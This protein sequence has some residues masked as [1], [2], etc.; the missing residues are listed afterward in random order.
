MCIVA[1]VLAGLLV[2]L[3]V[4]VFV[5]DLCLCV[6]FGFVALGFLWLCFVFVWLGLL[7]LF[8][9]T[10][11]THGLWLGREWMLA[12]RREPRDE[13]GAGDR[14]GGTNMRSSTREPTPKWGGGGQIVL[15]PSKLGGLSLVSH[16]EPQK[17]GALKEKMRGS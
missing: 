5:C 9:G 7:C 15:S 16:L 6:C 3:L 1:C 17:R 2:C 13:D 4:C 14:R 10:P 12:P 8:E 11:R